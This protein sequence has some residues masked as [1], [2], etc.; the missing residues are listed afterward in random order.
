MREESVDLCGFTEQEVINNFMPQIES[1]GRKHNWTTEETIHQLKANYGGYHFCE[2]NMT[3]I[4]NPSSLIQALANKEMGNYM[5]SSY[6]A[7]L[8][9]K[10]ADNTDKFDLGYYALMDNIMYAYD[11]TVGG[12]ILFLYQ[13]GYITIKDYEMRIYR[14]GFPNQE[15]RQALEDII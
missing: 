13:F 10:F 3:E 6:T 5:D 12:I 7:A 11:V 14:L 4:F 8:F 9:P 15:A 2:R 1:L